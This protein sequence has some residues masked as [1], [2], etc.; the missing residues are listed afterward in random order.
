[1]T[2]LVQQMADVLLA[3]NC[4]LGDERVTLRVLIDAGFDGGYIVKL[5]DDVVERAQLVKQK[6]PAGHG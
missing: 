6:E 2:D 5:H 1:M 3:A 4:D